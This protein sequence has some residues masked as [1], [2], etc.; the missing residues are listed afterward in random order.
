MC[1]ALSRTELPAGCEVSEGVRAL[2]DEF[3]MCSNAACRK[4]YWQAGALLDPHHTIFLQGLTLSSCPH[5][6]VHLNEDMMH[7]G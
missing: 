2:H 1:R 3:W 4:I 6:L 7:C 5:V